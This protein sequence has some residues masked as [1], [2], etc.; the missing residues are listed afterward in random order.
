MDALANAFADLQE[1]LFEALVQPLAF[2]LGLG[3]RL[4]DAYDATGWLLIG[5]LQ[6]VVLLAVIGPL[7]RWP[8]NAL[9]RLSHYFVLKCD[10]QYPYSD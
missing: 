1:W 6:L 10:Y 8:I 9:A 2:S 7:Q 4:E 5:L 3:N